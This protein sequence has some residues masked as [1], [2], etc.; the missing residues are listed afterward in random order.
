MFDFRYHVASLAAVFVA[1]VIG[2]LVGVGLSG[3]GFVDDAERR[4]LND[5]IAALQ[6]QLD[7]ADGRLAA[8]DRRQ[9]A[10]DD[11]ADATYA[12]LIPGRL[13]NR[14]VAVL[15]VGQRDRLVDRAVGRAV[16]QAGGVVVRVRA[17]RVPVE[18]QALRDA[19]R[20]RPA[21]EGLAAAD[22]L[23]DVGEELARELVNG[24]RAPVWDALARTLVLERE[25]VSTAPADAIVVARS[26]EPQQGPSRELL[27]AVYETLSG[28]EIPAVGVDHQGRVPSAVAAFRAAGLSTVDSVDTSAGRLAL[29]L[30][31]AG[32]A[33]GSYGVE[34]DARNGVL[35]P[36]PPLQPSPAP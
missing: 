18:P 8:V 2:I 14:R 17:L 22:A 35:P 23:D 21:L 5:R 31:L 4:N 24:G 25:G 3:Q 28:L 29:V 20:R 11:Y 12:A 1:L 32:G 30:L 9:R 7:D 36:V 16:R 6:Q 13:E 33:P 27:A 10:L 19:L 26:A 15:F 34:E